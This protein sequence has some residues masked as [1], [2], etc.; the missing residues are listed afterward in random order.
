M[1]LNIEPKNISIIRKVLKIQED[2]YKEFISIS[3]DEF[4]INKF[5]EEIQKE[6]NK[7]PFFKFKKSK[8]KTDLEILNDL[9]IKD[10]VIEWELFYSY[11]NKIQNQKRIIDSLKSIIQILEKNINVQI[12]SYDNIF[13]PI[14]N[15]LRIK[16]NKY[17]N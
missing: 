11:D 4:A 5:K 6:R 8:E 1:F 14:L 7:K 10:Y 15:Y 9:F 13:N 3:R 16:E 2:E 12:N 17:E